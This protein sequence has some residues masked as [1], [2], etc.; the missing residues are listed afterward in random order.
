MDK[1]R[2][3]ISEENGT[4]GKWKNISLQNKRR[5][6]ALDQVQVWKQLFHDILYTAHTVQN[7]I[8]LD[9]DRRRLHW[10]FENARFPNDKLNPPPTFFFPLKKANFADRFTCK[11]LGI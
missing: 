7:C 8:S 2:S 1:I 4:H 11:R 9:T 3:S 10:I 5:S 6:T